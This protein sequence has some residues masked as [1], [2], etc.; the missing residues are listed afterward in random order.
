MIKTFEGVFELYNHLTPP[1]RERIIQLLLEMGEDPE[2]EK[3]LVDFR[4]E[5]VKVYLNIESA[6]TDKKAFEDIFD[7]WMIPIHLK[8]GNKTRVILTAPYTKALEKKV[9]DVKHHN[10]KI[11]METVEQELDFEDKKRE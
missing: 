1:R 4:G 11:M 6:K 3:K 7:F 9:V 8:H 2:T 5:Q 10:V